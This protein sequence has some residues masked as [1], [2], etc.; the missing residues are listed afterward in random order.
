MD[1]PKIL[2]S[3]KAHIAFIIRS[4]RKI[5]DVRS[6]FTDAPVNPHPGSRQR[7]GRDVVQP[8]HAIMGI[9]G[10][11]IDMSQLFSEQSHLRASGIG[12]H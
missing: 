12:R 6:G 1:I 5:C 4:P 3:A 8:G 2:R 11:G 9:S 10:V 7:L